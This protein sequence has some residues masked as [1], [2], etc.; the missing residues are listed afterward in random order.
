M[1]GAVTVKER[2]L[3]AKVE[4]ALLGYLKEVPFVDV[5]HVESCPAAAPGAPDL[6]AKLKLPG[7]EY[8]LALEVQASGQPR[9][10]RAAA[11]QLR[12]IRESLPNSYGVVAAPYVSPQAAEVCAEEG[13]GYV[14]LAGNFRLSF[15]QVYIRHEGNPNPKPRKRA[16]RSLYSPKAAR[17]LRVL[18]ADPG[19][20]WKMQPLAE[21]ARV[22]LGQTANVKKLLAD[23]EWLRVEASGLALAEPGQLLADW[24]TS[25]SYRCN[26]AYDLYTLSSVD[27]LEVTLAEACRRE[28][29]RCALTG[30]SAAARLA[31]AVRY[32]RA[33]AFVEGDLELLARQLRLKRVTTGANV[34]LL[35][36]YDEG[37]FYDLSERDGAP[38]VSPIQAYLDLQ[39]PAER[40][41][42]AAAALLEEVIKPLWERSMQATGPR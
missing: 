3:A 33:S 39:G 37:V 23:R 21:E 6:L 1:K 29:I 8:V 40:G 38:I 11:G 4:D 36:P 25:Y 28:G 13:V 41:E 19:R 22:S 32:E 7:G 12:R 14:D 16:L 20:H 5:E 31:P 9:Q 27:E 17:V 15:G 30:L 2:D 42:E 34:R 18:L 26:R 10:V 24:A 35:A